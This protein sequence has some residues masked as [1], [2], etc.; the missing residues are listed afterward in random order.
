MN[1]LERRLRDLRAQ[2]KKGF[3]GYLT[4]GDPSI[5]E[6]LGLMEALDRGG[7]DVIEVGIPFSDPLADGP[8]I[9]AAGQRA[10][11]KDL[12]VEE[13]FQVVR[14]FKE[15]SGTPLAFLV[16]TNTIVVYGKDEFMRACKEIGVDALIVPDLPYE[17]QG[18]IKAEADAA[19]IALIPFASPTS[20]DRL[21][22]TLKEGEGFVY[23]VS[24][25][26]VTGRDSEFHKDLDKYIAAVKE[27]TDL[28]VAVGF[29]ISTRED[30][31][32]MAGIADAVIVGTAIVRKIEESK[33]NPF[34][35]EAF[36]R[37]LSSALES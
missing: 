30:V 9:Q 24:S 28:P 16:Y 27:N 31:V 21:T 5:A 2:G 10:I 3:I 23:C 36:V 20:G 37:E 13:I 19:G 22:Y 14:R 1:P 4:A 12:G 29:G 18:E 15:K 32:R 11:E 34:V 25:M 33:G 17:E 8:V 35:V 7:C 26:G 6:T